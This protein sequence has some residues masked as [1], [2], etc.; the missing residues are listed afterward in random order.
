MKKTLALILTLASEPGGPYRLR[1][2]DG[3]AC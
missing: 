3:N 2:Q 1:I